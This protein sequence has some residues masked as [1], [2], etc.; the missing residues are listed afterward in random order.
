MA[1]AGDVAIFID[2]IKKEQAEAVLAGVGLSVASAVH[3]MLDRVVQDGE[4]PFNPLMPNAET[5]AAMEAARRG[6]FV[7]AGPPDK[8]IEGLNDE[9]G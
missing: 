6:E 8:L 2:K 3:L 1:M 4:L 9:A 7:W 5:V